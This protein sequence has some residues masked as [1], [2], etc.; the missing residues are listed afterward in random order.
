MR[1]SGGIAAALCVSAV[2]SAT[3]AAANGRYPASTQVVFSTDST[4]PALVVVRTTYGL[5]V[6]RDGGATWRWVCEDALGVPSVSVEDPSIALTAN[7]ALLVG[8]FE[9]LEVSQDATGG[10][11]HTLGC[12]FGC[13]GGPLAG[14]S[15]VDL[16]GVPGS[17]H[18]ALALSSTYVWDDAGDNA[19]LDSRVWQ[20]PDDGVSWSQVGAAFDPTVSL[21]TLD[22]AA[23]DPRRLYLSGTRAFGS[24]RTASLFVSTDGGDTWTERPLPFDP[25]TEVSVYI[26]AVDPRD[27]DRVYVRSSGVSRLFVTSDAGRSFEVPLT[28]TGQMLGFALSADG[29]EVYAGSI[30]DGLLVAQAAGDVIGALAF[31][32]TSSIHVQCLATRGPELWACSDSASGFAVG[33]SM[34]DGAAFT[35]K[36]QP[37]GLSSPVACAPNAQGP[38]AC[39]A[40]ANASQCGGETFEAV[41]ASLGGCGPDAGLGA[42]EGEDASAAGAPRLTG[43]AS[44]QAVLAPTPSC[45]C[46]M[47]PGR[48]TTEAGAACAV[49]VV[50]MR[51]RRRRS[52]PPGAQ[53]APTRRPRGT[54]RRGSYDAPGAKSSF[55]FGRGRRHSALSERSGRR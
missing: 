37:S 22:V 38:F 39:G 30:E 28:L 1:I 19:T 12:N 42:S 29:T 2:L 23:S 55:S 6:S 44:T 20:T 18:T 4:D 3:G 54:C 52:D 45:G 25:A 36:L 53:H 11:P 8:L 40:T 7:D 35:P 46:T 16:A 51:R 27:A 5:L 9:G 15:I 10:A 21:T 47:V 31:R 49:A 32:K 48:G 13:V 41:C 33:V 43:D 14:Q 17:P 34:N 26:G 24:G 50:A